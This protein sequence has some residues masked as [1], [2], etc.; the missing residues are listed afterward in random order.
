MSDWEGGRDQRTETWLVL[1]AIHGLD[2]YDSNIPQAGGR[3]G[4]RGRTITTWPELS[5]IV[6]AKLSSFLG[7]S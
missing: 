1:L 3:E 7:H 2:I 5:L 6:S 4:G